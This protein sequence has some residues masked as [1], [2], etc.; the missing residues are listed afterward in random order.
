MPDHLPIRADLLLII[1]AAALY[2][3]DTAQ[4]LFANEILFVREAGRWRACLPRDQFMISRRFL[5]LPALFMPDATFFRARWPRPETD[6]KSRSPDIRSQIDK[7][8][9]KL[10]PV[11]WLSV[12]LL[13]EIFLVL[14]AVYVFVPG[15]LAT[16]V[17]LLLIYHQALAMVLILFLKRRSLGL[18]WSVAI[19]LGFESLI[20]VPYAINLY[21]KTAQKL[22]PGDADVLELES[23]LL[24]DDQRPAFRQALTESVNRQLEWVTENSEQAQALVEFRTRCSGEDSA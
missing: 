17:V 13:P 24:T 14:P 4:L 19:L 7:D 15:Y 10:T 6:S 20:C 9:K 16:F 1:I 18:D 22:L 11:K 2:L 8:F 3:I 23:A 21:R 5:F 12:L